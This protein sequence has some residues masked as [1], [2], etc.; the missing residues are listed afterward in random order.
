MTTTGNDSTQITDC[1]ME[2]KAETRN[3]KDME[4]SNIVTIHAEATC[5][6][7]TSPVPIPAPTTHQLTTVS[8]WLEL[9]LQALPVKNEHD[10]WPLY[11]QVYDSEQGQVNTSRRYCQ[12]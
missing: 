12:Y 8:T 7:L 5:S 1:R 6:L 2:P 4:W 9:N 3:E 10:P 11:D